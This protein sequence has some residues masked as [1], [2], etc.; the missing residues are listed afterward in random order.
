MFV[1]VLAVLALAPDSF[2]AS[3]FTNLGVA[4][5]V[6]DATGASSPYV[7]GVANPYP[8]TIQVFGMTGTI[9][10]ARV[11]IAGLEHQNIDDLNLL[12]V[13]PDGRGIQL[14]SD[15]GGNQQVGTSDS[16]ISISFDDN[17]TD[18][19]PDDGPILPTHDYKP[20][21][22]F[23]GLGEDA[24]FATTGNTGDVYPSPAPPASN[25]ASNTT[26]AQA[27]NGIDPNGTWQLFVTDDKPGGTGG[28]DPAGAYVALELTTGAG[29]SPAT[30]P[31]SPQAHFTVAK[32]PTSRTTTLLDASQSL[33]GGAVADSFKWDVNSDGRADAECPG[34]DPVLMTKFNGS[35]TISA[36][37]TTSGGGTTSSTR[38]TTSVTGIS[39]SRR[40]KTSSVNS[41]ASAAS[42]KRQSFVCAAQ[43]YKDD[44][45]LTAGGGPPAGCNQTVEFD[46]VE[47]WG[48]LTTVDSLAG[49]PAKEQSVL[50]SV[51]RNYVPG[52]GLARA[53]GSTSVG[54]KNLVA[55][56]QRV[57]AVSTQPV[58]LNGLDF[59]PKPGA[60]IVLV[61]PI[62]LGKL[63]AESLPA[64]IVSSN[65]TVGF[66]GATL[67]S[68]QIRIPLGYGD[69]SHR[70]HLGDFKLA[71]LP[72]VGDLPISG[73]VGVDLA[74]R[75]T[76]IHVAAQLPDIFRSSDGGA[77][78]GAGLL[79]LDNP[80]GLLLDQLEIKVPHAAIGGFGVDN[81]DFKYARQ[82]S[83]WDAS[84]SVT[85]PPGASLLAHVLIQHGALKYLYVKATPPDPGI[86]SAPGVFIN[87]IDFTY[88][89][90][91][92]S[93]IGGG[94]GVSAGGKVSV[95]WGDGQCSLIRVDG[96]FF[97]QF[98]DPATYTAD[99]DVYLLCVHLVH[100]YYTANTDGHFGIGGD[101]DFKIGDDIE[102]SARIDAAADTNFAHTQIDADLEACVTFWIGGGCVGAEA[103]VSDVGVGI[104]ADLGFT[105]AGGGI[106]FPSKII[107]FADS[108]DISPFRP[109][110]RTAHPAAAGGAQ[111]FKWGAG[112]PSGLV[113]VS[114]AGGPPTFT[115]SGPN[116]RTIHA[117]AEQ[118]TADFVVVPHGADSTTYL[119]V[120]KPAA[121][122]WTV[123]PDAGV[124][125]TAVKVADGLPAP[126]VTA[127][128]GGRGRARVLAYKIAPAAGQK[129]TFA[130]RGA[131]DA[132]Q[133]GSA[134]G[135][136]GKLRFTV[137]PTASGRQQVIARIVRNGVPREDVVVGHFNARPLVL[138][139]PRK[140]KVRRKSSRAKLSWS[141]VAGA[142][143]Y[144]VSF[145]LSDGNRSNVVTRHRSLSVAN[146]APSAH[147]VVSVRGLPRHGRRGAKARAKLKP[148]RAPRIRP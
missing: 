100:G 83:T 79:T 25:W 44:R 11:F 41:P 144:L 124:D 14:M 23:G 70:V 9:V 49:I 107:L 33:A 12:L 53:S 121:G 131:R 22:Y 87:Y 133:I 2:A 106:V 56:Q 42:T 125:L 92:K 35:G 45:D 141:A 138:R 43:G 116:G 120:R 113:A 89:G 54:V 52:T 1:A 24:N 128:L 5:P 6:A 147:G 66:N 108:C 7:P 88:D 67:D 115:L 134:H 16:G 137:S 135:A 103:A 105:H 15:A 109:L 95:P 76:E 40:T 84:G 55:A 10:H 32:S 3:D 47:A 77:V 36:T 21:N 69:P 81:L 61:G 19:V 98:A 71:G 75:R 50:S 148:A 127:K 136:Q 58:R 20:S 38:I 48:C 118:R 46:I 63:N 17:A 74:Y 123:T 143:R 117:G 82:D 29:S 86:Q 112:K 59:T 110:G 60:A 130:L 80:N 26:L 122:T 132:Q 27:F 37:L 62:T 114:A 85:F 142:K 146:L 28:I 18:S 101:A 119:F 91:D 90:G 13:A 93:G 72:L 104:C 64:F 57:I 39:S 140:L 4:V 65:A 8:T 99:G 94:I 145:R 111:S 97:L 126:K 73:K 68:G 96:H 34:S 102:F 78:T 51:T 129:V 139:A 30:T 31:P